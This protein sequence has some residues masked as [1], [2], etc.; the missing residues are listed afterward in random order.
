[1]SGDVKKFDI[2]FLNFNWRISLLKQQSMP[3]NIF[4]D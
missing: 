4:P 3:N 1:M 2:A